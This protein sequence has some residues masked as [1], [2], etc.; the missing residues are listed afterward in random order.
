MG[1]TRTVLHPL[2]FPIIYP[3]EGAL[4]SY[5]SIYMLTGIAIAFFLDDAMHSNS[6][7]VSCSA[8][9][10]PHRSLGRMWLPDQTLRAITFV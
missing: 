6:S 10:A 4:S 7:Q 2:S 8:L 3:L 1:G 9:D 5:F